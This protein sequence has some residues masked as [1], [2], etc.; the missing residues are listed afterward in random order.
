MLYIVVVA[1]V[2]VFTINRYFR[3]TTS[4]IEHA[5]GSP[6]GPSVVRSHFDYY[7]VSTKYR[8]G[9]MKGAP[10]CCGLEAVGEDHSP[11]SQQIVKALVRWATCKRST[12]R[13]PKLSLITLAITPF[14]FPAAQ[15][16][17]GFYL[18]SPQTPH[19]RL[20]PKGKTVKTLRNA[21]G[22]HLASPHVRM[23]ERLRVEAL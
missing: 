10:L 15:N 7:S 6:K 3:P 9:Q 5:Q 4:S 18:A 1:A 21:V 23:Q 11:K 20:P 17:V 16:A 8:I 14:V 13:L 19:V 22:F 12:N 2:A